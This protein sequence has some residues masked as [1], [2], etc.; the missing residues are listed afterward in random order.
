MPVVFGELFY[1]DSDSEVIKILNRVLLT[2]EA[3]TRKITITCK[4]DILPY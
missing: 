3:K 4:L 1:S 2:L